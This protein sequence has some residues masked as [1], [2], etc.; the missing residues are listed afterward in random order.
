[1]KF[2]IISLFHSGLIRH[3]TV[4]QKYKGVECVPHDERPVL[5]LG[6]RFGKKKIQ[7]DHGLLIKP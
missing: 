5:H 4:I 6:P 1:V 3:E 7:E 2:I